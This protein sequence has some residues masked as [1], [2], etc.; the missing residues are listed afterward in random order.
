MCLA[1]DVTGKMLTVCISAVIMFIQV[2]LSTQ[3]FRVT[4]IKFFNRALIWL[5]YALTSSAALF[6]H[7]MYD[8]HI[9]TLLSFIMSSSLLLIILLLFSSS[10][11]RPFLISIKSSLIWCQ[12]IYYSD[13]QCSSPSLFSSSS[14]RHTSCIWFTCILLLSHLL[15]IRISWPYRPSLLNN[16]LICFRRFTLYIFVPSDSLIKN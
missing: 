1:V 11:L 16:L 4:F 8:M 2:I 7:N 6:M 10:F 5:S 15:A 9:M 13:P 3:K 14:G 12:L